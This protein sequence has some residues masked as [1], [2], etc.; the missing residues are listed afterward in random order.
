MALSKITKEAFILTWPGDEPVTVVWSGEHILVPG[1]NEIARTVDEVPGSRYRFP[2]AVDAE[3]RP[4]P[5][6]VVLA[7]V[8][9]TDAETGGQVKY[10]D[11]R[12]YAVG[13]EANLKPL[14]ARGLEI[15]VH[16]E[17]VEPT[18]AKNREKYEE[19]KEAEARNTVSEEL[20]RL[21]HWEKQGVPA[22]RSTSSAAVTEAM[23]FLETRKGAQTA[24][25]HK[26]DAL[27]SALGVPV[28]SAA[29]VVPQAVPVAPKEES[30]ASIVA[31][32]LVHNCEE[33]GINLTKPELMGLLKRDVNTIK[34]VSEKL[35]RATA[36]A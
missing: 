22:P 3:G 34:A 26:R 11:A 10:F 6:T 20:A 1:R 28:E 27:L 5:G 25:M 17:D 21:A 18:I 8:L 13:I 30:E 16:P 36:A 29:P 24:G 12:G 32:A 4:I 15:V 23:R 33:A 19:H 2:A 35:E 9:G 14:L 7:D 31:E